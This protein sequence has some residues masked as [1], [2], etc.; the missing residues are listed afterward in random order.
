MHTNLILGTDHGRPV[1]IDP[2]SGRRHTVPVDRTAG[3][4][5]QREARQKAEEMAATFYNQLT[6]KIGREP[7]RDELL[8]GKVKC[9][10]SRSAT[11]IGRDAR[12]QPVRPNE[13]T[14]SATLE[15]FEEAAAAEQLQKLSP[16]ERQLRQVQEREAAAANQKIDDERRATHQRVNADKLSAYRELLSRENWNPQSDET[17]RQRLRKLVALYSEP[18]ASISER[19]QLERELKEEKVGEIRAR[20]ER[21]AAQ[22]KALAEQRAAAE[23]EL[24]EYSE[25][26]KPAPVKATV[27]AGASLEERVK[28][29]YN[30]DAATDEA[31]ARLSAV[32]TD[33]AAYREV[34]SEYVEEE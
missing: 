29:F 30:S 26:V 24:A 33:V 25:L 3:S 27:P 21:H 22:E 12:W 7:K 2:W 17:K 9:G 18:D 34:L 15:F 31:M 13:S 23:A 1:V 14:K 28:A 11:D 32:N 10:D 6:L 19:T 4:K 5:G 8:A 20:Q 16:R